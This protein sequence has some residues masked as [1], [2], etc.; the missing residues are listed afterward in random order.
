MFFVISIKRKKIKKYFVNEQNVCLCYLYLRKYY[1]M[2]RNKENCKEK[3]HFTIS[4]S[5]SY[6]ITDEV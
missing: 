3:D 4:S 5:I 6:H 2:A 1:V